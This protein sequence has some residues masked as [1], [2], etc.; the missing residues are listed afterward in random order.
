LARRAREYGE[1]FTLRQLLSTR[2]ASFWH[3]RLGVLEERSFRLFFIGYTTSLIGAAMVPVALT[4]ALLQQGRS[5]SDVGYVLAAQ[6]VPLVALLLIGGVLSDRLPRKLVMVSADLARSASE[7]LLAALVITGRPA[8]WA[9][10]VLAGVL[11]A[12]QA[13]FNP[14]MTGLMPLL[15]SRERL[16]G[17]NALRGVAN[18]TGQ[19]FG[20]AISGVIVAGIGAGWAIGID[21]ATYAISAYCL[22]RL[23]LPPLQPAS[24]ERF[25]AQLSEGW[26][27]FRSRTWLWVIVAQF[28][29]FHLLAYAPFI[30]LGAVI[31]RTAL[32][33]A[34]AWGLILAAQG[35]GA[36]LGGIAVISVRPT[37][38][39]VVGVIGT[40]LFAIPTALLALKVPALAVAAGAAA[41]GAGLAVFMALWDTTLQRE[42]PAAALSRVSSYDWLG[43]VALVPVGFAIAGPMSKALGTSPVLWIATAITLLSSALVLMVPSVRKVTRSR[44]PASELERV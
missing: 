43:S 37:H 31:A 12:G 23:T 7:L 1:L 35:L 4:F 15:V 29:I 33:G 38:P 8:L 6:T 17:A 41:S 3:R 10:I 34:G 11:G 28:G 25:L 14:A 26:T 39:L 27:E 20:P 40:G 2:R 36:F 18:S 5:V 9:F 44:S 42:V 13:L 24:A 32:G 16:Q 19:I 30:V 22:G 21:G